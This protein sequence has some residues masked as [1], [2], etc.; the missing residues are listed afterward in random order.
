MEVQR[1]MYIFFHIQPLYKMR[2]C[3]LYIVSFCLSIHVIH[4]I[5]VCE[6]ARGVY[7]REWVG[8]CLLVDFMHITSIFICVAVS[9]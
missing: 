8:V 6:G 9:S 7:V 3:F 4:L 2:V 5:D 1:T